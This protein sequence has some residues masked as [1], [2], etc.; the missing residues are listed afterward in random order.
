MEEKIILEQAQQEKLYE[1]AISV[2]ERGDKI[3]NEMMHPNIGMTMRTLFYELSMAWLAISTRK[4]SDFAISDYYMPVAY[5]KIIKLGSRV[6]HALYEGGDWYDFMDADENA[7][8]NEIEIFKRKKILDT[9]LKKSSVLSALKET[10][11]YGLAMGM[12]VQETVPCN[13]EKT[14]RYSAKEGQA[15]MERTKTIPTKLISS[16]NVDLMDLYITDPYCETLDQDFGILKEYTWGK[17]K[18]LETNG[19]FS[20]VSAIKDNNYQ[21]PFNLKDSYRS[22]RKN[23]LKFDDNQKQQGGIVGYGESTKYVVADIWYK[24]PEEIIVHEEDIETG[25]PIAV[26]ESIDCW[27]VVSICG[28]AILRHK[29]ALDLFGVNEPPYTIWKDE[30]LE[31]FFYGYGRMARLVKTQW[32]QNQIFNLGI[33][34]IIKKLN[35]NFFV[36]SKVKEAIDAQIKGGMKSGAMIAVPTPTGMGVRETIYPIEYPDPSNLFLG[37]SDFL[38]NVFSN[39]TRSSNVMSGQPTHSQLDRTATAYQTAVGESS[40]DI[41]DIVYSMQEKLVADV[42]TKCFMIVSR[43]MWKKIL[44]GKYYSAEEQK[45]IQVWGRPEDMYGLP[46]ID[47]YGGS[48]Y[49][50]RQKQIQDLL[51]ILNIIQANAK[52][53]ERVKYEE[54][55]QKIIELKRISM[56][57]IRTQSPQEMLMEI[58]NTGVPVE[59]L[60]EMIN[61]LAFV[62]Q[63]EINQQEAGKQQQAKQQFIHGVNTEMSFRKAQANDQKI[64]M[65]DALVAESEQEVGI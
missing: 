25:Q 12:T 65:L 54:I 8:P 26:K 17:L 14:Y 6:N 62:K 10:T 30:Y 11:Y 48:L 5:E 19:Y 28:N 21:N 23:L 40:A 7:A 22:I 4:K 15:T 33:D 52:F 16:K 38:N 35:G 27:Y 29:K 24:Q 44:V 61:E 42:I 43:T 63:E 59:Q 20:D 31:G 37:A 60:Q 9:H 57:V 1:K 13:D 39:V 53:G 3:L 56:D 47:V 51:E 18:K 45:F 49:L 46:D 32:V 55:M 34:G 58:I 2:L 64:Q 41:K 36:S 50:D